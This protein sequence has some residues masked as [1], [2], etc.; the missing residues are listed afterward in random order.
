MIGERPAGATRVVLV[1]HGDA[2]IA[3]GRICGRL[4]PPL[5]AAGRARIARVARWLGG[6]EITSAHASPALRATQTARLLCAGRGLAVATVAGLREVDFG[7]FEGLTWEEASAR[8]PGTCE[9]WLARPHEVAFPGGE[10]LGAVRARALAALAALVAT[11]R[12]ETLLVVAHAGP[13]RAILADALGMDPSATF[14]IP[15]APG[16]VNVLDWVDRAVSVRLVDGGPA[17]AAP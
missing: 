9:A 17:L 7:A 12:G 6:I 14:G 11:R 16:A 13:N 8:D 15:Q 4:D 10:G 2:A 3:A 1:R 5:C